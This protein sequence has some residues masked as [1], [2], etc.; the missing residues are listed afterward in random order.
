MGLISNGTT[1]FDAGALDSGLAKGAL[2]FIKKLSGG[3]NV[4]TMSFVNGSGGVVLDDT[5]KSYLF[6]FK[7]IH[8]ETDNTNLGFLAS[9]NAGSSYGIATTNAVYQAFHKEDDSGAALQ[10]QLGD[11][12]AQSTSLITFANALGSVNDEC[13]S[14]TFELYDPG[15]ATGQKGYL[16]LM[17]NARED[18]IAQDWNTAGLINTASAINAIRFQMSSGDIEG[19]DICLY[20]IS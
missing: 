14:G 18:S 13:A 17:S 1:I 4:A 15:S 10:K 3:S 16:T 6:T 8:P 19:G 9:S 7:N 11:D 5:Y 20:G 2:T 12:F